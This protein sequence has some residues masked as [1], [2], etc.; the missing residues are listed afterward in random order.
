MLIYKAPV[1]TCFLTYSKNFLPFVIGIG[2]LYSFKV[3]IHG[4]FVSFSIYHGKIITLLLCLEMHGHQIVATA[5]L[6]I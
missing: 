6:L 3:Q 5:E 2:L 1:E 4:E